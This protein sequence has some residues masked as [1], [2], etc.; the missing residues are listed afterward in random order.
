MSKHEMNE[1]AIV[2]FLAE[3][4]WEKYDRKNPKYPSFSQHGD[5]ITVWTTRPMHAGWLF[6]PFNDI[7]HAF[8]VRDKIRDDEDGDDL[9]DKFVSAYFR[10]NEFDEIWD[11][12]AER[13]SVSAVRALGTPEE[14]EECGL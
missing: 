5:E 9:R 14:I 4:L 11:V 13:I 1:P 10:Y 7:S 12:S 2:K 6:D 8:M 3:L